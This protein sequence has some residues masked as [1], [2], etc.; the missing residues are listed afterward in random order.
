M[1]SF[2]D[3]LSYV[4]QRLTGLQ[5]HAV[6]GHESSCANTTG[7]VTPAAQSLNVLGPLR[8]STPGFLGSS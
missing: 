6:H 2:S 7:T 4:D 8:L 5:K 3:P 1:P